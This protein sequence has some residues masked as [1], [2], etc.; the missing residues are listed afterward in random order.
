MFMLNT[1]KEILKK[2]LNPD[3]FNVGINVDESAG[4][5]VPNVHMN[6]IQRYKGYVKEPRGGVRGVIPEK[7]N[8]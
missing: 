6:L 2:E 5:T 3:G 8:Y 1:M 4:Q 7:K